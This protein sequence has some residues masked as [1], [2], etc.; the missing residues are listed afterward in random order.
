[1]NLGVFDPGRHP[2]N[3]LRRF[4]RS[5]D[6]AVVPVYR[7]LFTVHQETMRR[8]RRT[9]ATGRENTVDELFGT[10]GLEADPVVRAPDRQFPLRPFASGVPGD[11]LVQTEAKSDEPET[12]RLLRRGVE[13]E[14][15]GRPAEAAQRYREILR[16]DPTHLVA[17]NH[18]ALLLESDGN[19][20]GALEELSIGLRARPD[21][22][23]LL[24]TRGALYGKLKHYPEAEADLHRAIKL[25]P[26]QPAAHFNLGLVLWRKG[27]PADA[28]A[29][30]RRAIELDPGNPQAYYYLG[31]ALNQAKDLGGARAALERAAALDPGNARAFQ[32]L[33][34]IL[35]R[36]NLPDEAREMYRRARQA[37]A[38]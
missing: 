28:S 24:V 19:P 29:S 4:H 13:A 30:L 22:P 33:G 8:A 20:E 23:G 34:R 21:V 37:Q 10:S 1:V 12:E 25:A 6:A 38:R 14:R 32:L 17:R 9:R 16:L 5:L 35:D 3:R 2:L 18:L 27:L 7:S 26:E 11:D 15:R 36:L 31:E